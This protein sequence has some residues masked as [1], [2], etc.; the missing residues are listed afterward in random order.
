MRHDLVSQDLVW[1]KT[2]DL[3]ETG[4][5]AKAEVYGESQFSLASHTNIL[6]L[7]VQLV[8]HLKEWGGDIA[9]ATASV[10]SLVAT[11]PHKF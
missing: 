2:S 10:Q 8:G 1:C 4:G 11:V 6:G 7:R 9:L 3:H 5:T